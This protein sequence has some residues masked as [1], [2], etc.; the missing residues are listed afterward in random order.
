MLR[1]SD[2]P[3]PFAFRRCFAW[4]VV[5][6][7]VVLV[8]ARLRLHLP[9]AFDISAVAFAYAFDVAFAVAFAFAVRLLPF[10]VCLCV[11]FPIAFSCDVACCCG[12]CVCF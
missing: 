2:L 6:A 4:T 7:C 11:A 12:L 5:S 1:C 10:A 3:L 8:S 9:C